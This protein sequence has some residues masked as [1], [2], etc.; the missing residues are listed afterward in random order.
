M[1]CLLI[2]PSCSQW[3]KAQTGGQVAVLL[4]AWLLQCTAVFFF[5]WASVAI[6]TQSY[7]N[8]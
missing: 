4:C 7:I 8:I 3:P 5:G 6:A 1:C 2:F